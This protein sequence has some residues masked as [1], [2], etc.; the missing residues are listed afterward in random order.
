[1]RMVE[2]SQAALLA[3]RPRTIGMCSSG[4]RARLGALGRVGEN[5]AR[6]KEC[7]GYSLRKVRR[8]ELA[9][10]MACFATARGWVRKRALSGTNTGVFAEEKSMKSDLWL[11]GWKAGEA[12]SRTIPSVYPLAAAC[13]AAYK[14]G[15]TLPPHRL[16]GVR[17]PLKTLGAHRLAPVRRR[18]A[19]SSSRRDIVSHRL[20]HRPCLQSARAYSGKLCPAP[21]SIGVIASH[22][23]LLAKPWQQLSEGYFSRRE[24]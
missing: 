13:H 5:D 7:P 8:T 20:A 23:D 2:S 22:P 1:M 3:R 15:K 12:L 4:K 16:G 6:S 14:L 17:K 21:L 18:D 10:V 11:G 24:R 19:P 9:W